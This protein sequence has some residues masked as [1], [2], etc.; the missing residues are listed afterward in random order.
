MPLPTFQDP[1]RLRRA[2]THRSYLNEHPEELEDNERLEFLGD[3]VL[4][5]VTG[6]FVFHRF[7]EMSE[8][9]L[10]RL[11]AALVRTE[12]FAAFASELGV[13]QLMRLGKGEEEGGGRKRPTLLCDTFEA[14]VGAYYLD[15]GIEAVWAFVEPLFQTAAGQILAAERDMDPKSLLQEW[16][17]SV[18]GHTPRYHVLATSGPDHQKEFTVEVRVGGEAYGVGTGPNKQAAEQ[19]AA[20]AALQNVDGISPPGDAPEDV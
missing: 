16:A 4:D 17:Q 1:S 10:T 11:R 13:G 14:V 18:M 15:S 12:Q 6:A 9:R 7:P 8:G 2:L 19:A 5:F 3:A 20:R